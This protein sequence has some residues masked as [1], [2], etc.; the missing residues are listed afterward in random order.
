MTPPWRQQF[1]HVS[2][3][4]PV[5]KRLLADPENAWNLRDLWSRQS[6]VRGPSVTNKLQHCVE[7]LDT[8]GKQSQTRGLHEQK[9]IYNDKKYENKL[10][11]R[12]FNSANNLRKVSDWQ[13]KFNFLNSEAFYGRFH[14]SWEAFND[15]CLTGGYGDYLQPLLYTVFGWYGFEVLMQYRVWYD[16]CVEKHFE[17]NKNWP[18]RIRQ[19]FVRLLSWLK[20]RYF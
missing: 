16:A 19:I 7:S 14:L 3:V 13:H 4:S 12:R 9:K 5:I 1:Y 11:Y 2:P 20:G 8:E 15:L 18:T 17:I 10:K 6:R